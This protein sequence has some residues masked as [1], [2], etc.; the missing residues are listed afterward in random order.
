[1]IRDLFIK[2]FG[3]KLFSLILAGFIWLTV[4][5]IITEPK[6]GAASTGNSLV[7]VT[8]DNVPVSIVATAQNTQGYDINSN[9]VSVAVTGPPKLMDV[10][11]ANQIHAMVDLSTFDDKTKNLARRVDVSVPRGITVVDIVPAELMVVPPKK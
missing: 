11:Q 10:L 3:W 4:N 6:P 7:T 5:R 2:D 1:M 9:M 8:Y